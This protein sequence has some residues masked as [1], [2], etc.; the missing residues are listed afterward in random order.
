MHKIFKSLLCRAPPSLLLI[1]ARID[2]QYAVARRL[3]EPDTAMH[4]NIMHLACERQINCLKDGKTRLAEGADRDNVVIATAHVLMIQLEPVQAH[5]SC[6]NFTLR[7][8]SIVL[9]VRLH[10][11]TS[12]SSLFFSPRIQLAFLEHSRHVCNVHLVDCISCHFSAT[13]IDQT[14]KPF[15]FYAMQ[16]RS[17]TKSSTR[18]ETNKCRM[19][20]PSK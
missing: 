7:C 4:S 9:P 5:C 17:K 16:I 18:Q 14:A 3:S 11:R 10:L 1:C 12:P 8:K 13:S 15:V 20:N 2:V 6:S 19:E